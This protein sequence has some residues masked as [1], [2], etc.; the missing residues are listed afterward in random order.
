VVDDR[1][2]QRP[3]IFSKNTVTADNVDFADLSAVPTVIA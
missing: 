1:R 3:H 2:C